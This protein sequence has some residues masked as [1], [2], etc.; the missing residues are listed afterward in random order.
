MRSLSH[1]HIRSLIVPYPFVAF[2]VCNGLLVAVHIFFFAHIQ[3]FKKD[4]KS[5]YGLF[6]LL[7]MQIFSYLR[8]GDEW[9]TNRCKTWN[10]LHHRKT[11]TIATQ[12]RILKKWPKISLKIPKENR[13]KFKNFEQRPIWMNLMNHSFFYV[14][15]DWKMI[16][17]VLQSQN[18]AFGVAQLHHMTSTDEFYSKTKINRMIE[19]TKTKKWNLTSENNESKSKFHFRTPKTNFPQ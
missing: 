9:S 1:T 17:N 5:S 12:L 8:F 16:R 14:Q 10:E 4:K 3:F 7:R 19:G 2:V 13:T 11:T 18:I 15:N 6:L